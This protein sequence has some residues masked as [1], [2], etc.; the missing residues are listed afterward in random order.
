MDRMRIQPFGLFG[1]KGGGNSGLYIK[2]KGSDEFKTFSEVYGVV[3]PVKFSGLIAE[4]GDEIILR[5][6]GGGGYEDPLHRDPQRVVEDVREGWVSP[7]SAREDYGVVLQ[8]SGSG[9]QLDDEGTTRLRA[10]LAKNDY[11]SKGASDAAPSTTPGQVESS[12]LIPSE[13]GDG[14]WRDRNTSYTSYLST[15]VVHC[16]ACGKMIPKW[17][18]HVT[19]DVGELPFC[20]PDC[21]SLYVDYWLPKYAGDRAG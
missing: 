5:S 18:W 10:E 15:R 16:S 1:G 7:E 12:T 4:E 19:T 3:S 13:L 2:K 8:G 17:V 20:D 14:E 6:A 21:Q 11:E 9:M